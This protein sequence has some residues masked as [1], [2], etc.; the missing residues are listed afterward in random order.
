MKDAEFAR[1]AADPQ[2]PTIIDDSR[3]IRGVT[4]ELLGE[5]LFRV[6]VG[7]TVRIVAYGETG[8]GAYRP[9]LFWTAS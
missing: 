1:R 9:A 7:D 4:N 6:Y 2:V 3:R 8:H 5:N